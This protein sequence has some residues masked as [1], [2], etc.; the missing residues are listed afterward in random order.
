MRQYVV[1]ILASRSRRLYIGITG[2]LERRVE[3]HRL[4]RMGFTAKYRINRLV[5]CEFFD[6]VRDALQREKQLKGWR[7]QRKLDL[8][9]SVNPTWQDFL[10]SS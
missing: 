5:Y 8:I 10:P 7:R 2:Y 6:D 4:G 9:S 1:Y 3:W